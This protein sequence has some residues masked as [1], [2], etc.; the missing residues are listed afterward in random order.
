MPAPQRAVALHTVAKMYDHYKTC[1]ECALR[2]TEKQRRGVTK[3]GCRQCDEPVH[4]TGDCVAD[5]MQR[6]LLG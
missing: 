4:Q 2:A 1:R 6:H 5:H 3:Y